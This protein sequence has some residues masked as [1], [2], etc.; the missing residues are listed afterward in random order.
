MTTSTA[1]LTSI[2]NRLQTA[3]ADTSH[4]SWQA[5]DLDEAVR[6]ALAQISLAYGAEPLLLCGLDSAP[7]TTLQKED[8]E[9][10]LCGAE[11][12]AAT[13]RMIDRLETPNL[14]NQVPQGFQAWADR[15]AKRFNTLLDQV[16]TR[17]MQQSAIPPHTCLRWDESPPLW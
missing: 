4:F 2:R 14:N 13:S 16:R 7:L 1:T 5:D 15:A 3:L 9:T 6:R 17:R 11:Y 12:F 8:E 10:L